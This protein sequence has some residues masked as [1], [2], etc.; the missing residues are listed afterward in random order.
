[1]ACMVV[2]SLVF[3]L[4]P[5]MLNFTFET[6]REGRLYGILLFVLFNLSRMACLYISSDNIKN[7]ERE[8]RVEVGQRLARKALTSRRQV[9]VS[10][11]LNNAGR[12]LVNSLLDG[13]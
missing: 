9:A 6:I 7:L 10:S 8:Y 4:Y 3:T 2:T 12:N 5:K 1:M 11:L 13:F